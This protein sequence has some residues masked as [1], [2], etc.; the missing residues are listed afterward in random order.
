[1]N[2]IMKVFKTNT[3][4]AAHWQLFLRADPSR[5]LVADYLS[6]GEVFEMRKGTRLA[7]T[8]ILLPLSATQLEIKNIAVAPQLENQG[9]AKVL[10]NFAKGYA[11]EHHYSELV[12]GTGSTSF[13]QLYLYQKV[14]FR[15][16]GVKRNF[17]IDHYHHPIWENHLQLRDMIVLKM[18]VSES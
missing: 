7:A 11:H 4:T 9:L 3:I 12:I 8:I 6:Q 17:F 16:I 13:K 18:K 1:M 10:L 15:V 14:G 2:E 5:E